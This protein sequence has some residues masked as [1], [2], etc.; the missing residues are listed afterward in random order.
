MWREDLGVNA[1]NYIEGWPY[2]H[3]SKIVLPL[4]PLQDNSILDHKSIFGTTLETCWCS[5]GIKIESNSNLPKY[6]STEWNIN[7]LTDA[8]MLI[9]RCTMLS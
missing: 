8:L 3:G 2:K 6:I 1:G 5:K 9:L 7:M 4:L